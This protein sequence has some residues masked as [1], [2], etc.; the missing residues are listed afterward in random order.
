ML[1]GVTRR[2]IRIR[3][4]INAYQEWDSGIGPEVDMDGQDGQLHVH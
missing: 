2:G 4:N 1:D 3:E